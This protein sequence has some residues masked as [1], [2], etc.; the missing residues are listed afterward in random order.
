MIQ[1]FILTHHGYEPGLASLRIYKMLLND[2]Q[3][4]PLQDRIVSL[5]F[6][7]VSWNKLMGIDPTYLG[8]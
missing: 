7:K 3:C 5:G 8:A 4:W 6:M 2:L 1:T